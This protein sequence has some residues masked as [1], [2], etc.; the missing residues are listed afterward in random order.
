MKI[1]KKLIWCLALLPMT[2][3]AQ[4]NTN[5][6]MTISEFTIKP[7]H[8]DQFLEGVKLWKE[9]YLKNKGKD[10][11]ALW[12]RL[13]GEGNVYVLTGNMVNWA[14]MDEKDAAGEASRNIARDF[15]WPNIES[16]NFS[17]AQ[18][19]PGLSGKPSDST[20]L[21]WVTYFKVNK[22]RVFTDV[23]KDLSAVIR[24]AEGNSRGSWF[25]LEG[26]GPESPNY[27]VV[28][29]AG[30][31]SDLDKPEDNPFDVYEKAKGKEAADALILKANSSIT[32]IWSYIYTLKE[33]LSN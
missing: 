31:F 18:R 30:G 10:H 6:L 15:I 20:K 24:S 28:E 23:V 21:V 32:N 33:D 22:S 17:I 4:E 14:Q 26:G 8:N 27:F 5:S 1:L 16:S 7:G 11:W 25:H 19:M 2:A 13:Q 29:T 3:I 9:T 12:H